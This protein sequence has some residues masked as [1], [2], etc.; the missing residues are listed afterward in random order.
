MSKKGDVGL[1]PPQFSL[2]RRI[3]YTVGA[4]GGVSVSQPSADNVITITAL[5]PA[6]ATALA[7]VLP[8]QY[9][10]GGI[11]VTIV[12]KDG[13]GTVHNPILIEPTL[14][15]AS[16]WLQAALAGNP[17]AI[18]V[19]FVPKQPLGPPSGGKL[20]GVLTPSVI[21]YYNDNTNDPYSFEHYVAQD[22][23]A[24]VI[25]AH[26][27]AIHVGFTTVAGL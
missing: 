12:V 14:D 6:A 27:G 21:Q 2:Q 18:G 24:D 19:R 9:D 10:F 8:L 26:L 13:T 7:N 20:Y 1:S 22:L 23:F 25:K 11:K 15:Q 16:G 3:A 17:Y 4:S 5:D